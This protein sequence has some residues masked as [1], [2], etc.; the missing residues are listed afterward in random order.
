MI[1]YYPCSLYDRYLRGWNHFDFQS[2][3]RNGMAAERI[4]INYSKPHILQ[5][6]RY[7]GYGFKDRQRIKRYTVKFKNEAALKKFINVTSISQQKI[8]FLTA[9]LIASFTTTFDFIEKNL[10]HNKDIL[11]IDILLNDSNRII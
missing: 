3:T 1:S 7:L 2:M 9:N 4:Y 11:A 5:D 10:L 6:Y 8:K